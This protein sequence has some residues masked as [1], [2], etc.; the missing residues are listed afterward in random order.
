MKCLIPGQPDSSISSSGLRFLLSCF[1]LHVMNEFICVWLISVN[2]NAHGFGIT[3]KLR[4]PNLQGW[5][6]GS[7]QFCRDRGR[8]RGREVE[9]EARQGMSLTEAR[10]GRGRGRELEAEARQTEFEARSRRG[11]PEKPLLP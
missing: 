5:A 1:M 10:Q 6:V 4:N 11:D 9:A 7:R 8:G 2:R 3:K